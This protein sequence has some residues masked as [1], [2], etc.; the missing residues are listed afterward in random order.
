MDI[1]P[2]LRQTLRQRLLARRAQMVADLR[3]E[4]HDASGQMALR[5]ERGNT[6]DEA[7]VEAM[8]ALEIAATA[9][10]ADELAAIDAALARL[11]TPDYGVC[12][13]CG[14]DIGEARLLAEPTALRCTACQQRWEHLHVTPAGG[15]L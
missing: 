6:D 3:A 10:D 7:V 8:D 4:A 9:R 15:R 13:D 14:A 1:T 5:S 12:I 2:Q 11:D